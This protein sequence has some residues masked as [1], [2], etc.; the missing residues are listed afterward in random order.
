MG[1]FEKCREIMYR[2]MAEFPRLN[3]YLKVAKYEIKHKN[4][5][6]ARK[7]FEKTMEDLG[8]FDIN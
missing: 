8:I 7:I 3:T 1:E 4:K 2:Y 5:D 6:F